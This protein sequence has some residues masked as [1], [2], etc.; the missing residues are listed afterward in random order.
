M[1]KKKIVILGGGTGISV[2]VKG[3]KNLDVDITAIINV[4]DDGSSTGK[5]RNEFVMPAVGDIR[6]AIVNLSDASDSVKDLLNYRFNTY[7][8]LNGHPIGNLLMVASYNMTGSLGGSIRLLSDLFQVRHKILPL[9]EDYLTLMAETLDGEIIEGESAIGNS[10]KK[11]KRIFYKEDIHI[12]DE[13]INEIMSADLI[14]FSIGSLYT[15]I[16]PNLISSDVVSAIDRSSARVLYVCNAMTQYGETDDFK[17]SDH[18]KVINSFLGDKKLD[19]VV[20]TNS[21]IPDVVIENYYKL[22]RKNLVRIDFP[23][24][25]NMGVYIIKD[26]LLNVVNGMVRHDSKK[27]A[28]VIYD[29]LMR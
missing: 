7:S 3:L 15:S 6:Q 21:L 27:L 18:L 13:V 10:H 28:M 29:Y 26:D 22:E 5:L 24:L 19:A 9:S 16:I 20:V 11:Y 4:S 23:E 14:I 25:M 8:D 17:A 2:V 12:S 1:G